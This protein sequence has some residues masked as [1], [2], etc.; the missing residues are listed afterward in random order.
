ME[1]LG[2]KQTSTF[3]GMES[4]RTSEKD[5]ARLVGQRRVL[6]G[7]KSEP[8]LKPWASQQR[9]QF[10]CKVRNSGRDSK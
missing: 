1:G 3:Y 4:A 2:E 6:G 8:E 10:E 5:C 9:H 7:G